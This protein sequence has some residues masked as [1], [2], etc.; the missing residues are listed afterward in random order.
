[1]IEKLMNIDRR[2]IFI[3]I[4]LS[5]II[6][7]VLK[8]SFPIT[9][10]K[11]TRDIYN[12]IEALPPGS[13]LMLAFDFGPGSM[14]ELRPMAIAV[15]RHCFQ[16]KI[17][18]IGMTLSADGVTLGDEIMAEVAAEA[19]V[20]NGEDYAYLGYRPGGALVLREM[21]NSIV[22]VF[23]KDYAGTPLAEISIMKDIVNYEQID[24][25]LDLAAGDSTDTW[26]TYTNIKFN[27]KVAAG[28]TGVIVSQMYPYLQTGQLVGLMPGLLGA[29]EYEKLVDAPGKGMSGMS[30]QSFVH[31]LIFAL[32]ILGN[33]AF[34]RQR[35]EQ[36]R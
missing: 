7:T 26:I 22:G 18:V 12:H 21:G 5:V 2:I 27:Q 3:L 36:Q 1:M 11:P 10:S 32:V 4:F 19:G 30:I 23:D 33:I 34:L 20:T 14:A 29:A 13:K 16:K 9:V 6:P 17:R 31:L 25:V 24:L 28:V 35:R 8:V 15:M